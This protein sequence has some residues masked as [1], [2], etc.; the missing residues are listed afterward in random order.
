MFEA[1]G[2]ELVHL[3]PAGG[4]IVDQP[5]VLAGNLLNEALICQVTA[6]LNADPNPKC[7]SMCSQ[8]TC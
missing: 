8:A 2:Q 5:T 4:Y 6:T 1:G 3:D 7:S